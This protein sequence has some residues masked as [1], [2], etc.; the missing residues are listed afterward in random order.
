MKEIQSNSWWSSER[1]SIVTTDEFLEELW[2]SV[3]NSRQKFYKNREGTLEEFL[4]ELGR[5]SC[6]D[7]EEI[8]WEAFKGTLEEIPGGIFQRNH[9]RNFWGKSPVEFLKQIP[10]GIL[11]GNSGGISEANLRRNSRRTNSS[12]GDNPEGIAVGNSCTKFWRTSWW[13][14]HEKILKENP[15]KYLEK[16]LVKICRWIPKGYPRM[17]SW[18]KFFV[19]FLEGNP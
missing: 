9:R 11:G 1:I 8:H 12:P 15:G 16:Y 2:S 3:V 10:G 18:S 14:S 6:R 13:K 17:N 4:E 7:S 5:N 19:E